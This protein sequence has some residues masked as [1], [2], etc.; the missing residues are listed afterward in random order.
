MD[1]IVDQNFYFI[2]ILGKIFEKMDGASHSRRRSD[3][4]ISYNQPPQHRYNNSERIDFVGI[5]ISDDYSQKQLPTLM[6]NAS[7]SSQQKQSLPVNVQ[8]KNSYPSVQNSVQQQEL[9]D[10]H[11][12]RRLD[13]YVSNSP[14]GH[15][16]VTSQHQNV[17][18]HHQRSLSGHQSQQQSS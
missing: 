5:T 10:S 14:S 7:S 12:R 4:N 8:R 13:N 6:N 17:Q 15:Y 16:T 2:F 3:H 18:R 1:V 11:S 9:P